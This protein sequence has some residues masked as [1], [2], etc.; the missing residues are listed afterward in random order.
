MEIREAVTKRLSNFVHTINSRWLLILSGGSF[1]VFSLFYPPILTFSHIYMSMLVG[2]L[3]VKSGLPSL[4]D[5]ILG[6]PVELP[7]FSMVYDFKFLL[8][9]HYGLTILGVNA[10]YGIILTVSIYS[11]L[12]RIGKPVSWKTIFLSALSAAMTLYLVGS[13][14]IIQYAPTIIGSVT[15]IATKKY[16]VKAGDTCQEIAHE[17]NTSVD[18]I[19]ELNGLT[20]ECRISVRQLLYLQVPAP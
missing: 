4:P 2:Y 19:I 3:S 18:S 10:V 17:Y 8:G 20:S 16:V 9:H 13:T 14:V 11:L 1:L 6:Y 12:R 7:Y 5:L 15:S